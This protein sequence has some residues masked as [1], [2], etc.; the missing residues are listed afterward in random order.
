MLCRIFKKLLALG[1]DAAD[2]EDAEHYG[3][4]EYHTLVSQPVLL[5]E[6]SMCQPCPFLV[7]QELT[8]LQVW[9]GMQ[10]RLEAIL[11]RRKTERLAAERAYRQEERVRELQARLTE[12]AFDTKDGPE[13]KQLQTCEAWLATFPSTSEQLWRVPALAEFLED[14]RTP[15]TKPVFDAR[16][17]RILVGIRVFQMQT[18]RAFAQLLRMASGPD[19][20]PYNLKR[21]FLEACSDDVDI[22]TLE[23]ED[24]AN[25]EWL[26]HPTAVFR[27][28]SHDRDHHVAT[29]PLPLPYNERARMNRFY[30][31]CRDL[32]ANASRLVAAYGP[33]SRPLEDEI[34]RGAK[35]VCQCCPTH[36][37]QFYGKW[38]DLVRF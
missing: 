13:A 16:R 22:S 5:S 28:S 31:Y 17:D 23:R 35:F 32:Y 38:P 36:N 29:Y 8:Y 1:W 30:E 10:P 9:K 15:V 34:A 3:Q 12:L 6:K 26:S 25:L 2:M 14:D 37:Q 27:I 24:S 4:K 11:T 18:R 7:V 33:D 20:A 21:S 19:S